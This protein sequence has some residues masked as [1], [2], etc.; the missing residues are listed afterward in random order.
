V[1]IQSPTGLFRPGETYAFSM[2]ARL[3]PETTGSADIRFVMKPAYAWIGNTTMTADA[4]TTVTGEYTVPA[5]AD[6][7]GMQVYLGT[8]D[9]DGPY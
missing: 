5:D 7:A 2:W 4:W 1:G 6:P 8:S 9:L 3:A